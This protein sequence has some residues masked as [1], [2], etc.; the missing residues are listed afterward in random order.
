MPKGGGFMKD[1]FQKGLTLVEILTVISIISLLFISLLP[2][3][4]NVFI[5]ANESG[6]KTNF[7]EFQMAAQSLLRDSSGKGVNKDNLNRYLDVAHK[8]NSVDSSFVTSSVDSWGNPYLV[9]FSDRKIMFISNGKTEEKTEQAYTLVSY[10]YEGAVSSCTTG[11]PQNI[12][13][14]LPGISETFVCG[15][16]LPNSNT[17]SPFL[18]SDPLLKPTDFRTNQ[19]TERSVNVSWRKVD[20]ATQYI[21]KRNGVV[22]YSGSNVSYTDTALN[23]N[24]TYTYEV[25]ARST[26]A[27]SPFVSLSATTIVGPATPA[28]FKAQ[29]PS[30][31]SVNLSWEPSTYA[32]GYILYR[33]NDAIYQGAARS[34]KNTNLTP[35]TT[36]TYKLVA[37]NENGE[38]APV[39]LTTKTVAS[40]ETVKLPDQGTG[41]CNP[42]NPY[43][44]TTVGELQ[45]MQ[46]DLKA[47]YKLEKNIN[48][49]P[50]KYWND[51]KGFEPIGDTA[52]YAVTPSGTALANVPEEIAMWG[53]FDGDGYTISNLYINRPSESGVGLFVGTA[54]EIK[55]VTLENAYV[56]GFKDV[57]ILAGAISELGSVYNVRITGTVYGKEVVGG[58]SALNRNIIEDV[59]VSATVYNDSVYTGGVVADNDFGVMRDVTFDGKIY[60]SSEMGGL[61]GINHGIVTNAT[62]NATLIVLDQGR[63]ETIGGAFGFNSGTISDVTSRA[64]ITGHANAVGGFVGSNFETGRIQRF[65][66]NAQMNVTGMYIG[67]VFGLNEGIIE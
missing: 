50:T 63:A 33:D 37:M 36:Y 61:T 23:A 58:L 38:S 42:Y 27:V 13:L 34:Y 19:I 2:F 55:N 9:E 40:E 10:Y 15:H 57:G 21:L 35:Y 29:S 47:C 14:D 5:K 26:H 22:I 60:G 11:F 12:T 16:E 49:A 43:I 59:H 1:S 7:H 8:I 39:S 4:G 54:G 31:S 28:N 65:T 3:V 32:T 53:D 25:A 48:A 64:T 6:V 41:S 44:I 18:P 56:E 52:I 66:S 20:G 24:T 17:S 30:S 62:S 67:D 45:G 51:G 46:L